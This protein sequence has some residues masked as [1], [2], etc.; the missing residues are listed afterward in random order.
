M[1]V[2]RSKY[3]PGDTV[4]AFVTYKP[5]RAAETIMPVELDLPKDLPQG[6]YQLVISDAV[7]LRAGIDLGA[8]PRHE[9]EIRGRVERL[10]VRAFASA[11]DLPVLQRGTAKRA[12]RVA[13]E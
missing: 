5:F 4:K 7:A 1:N 13:A 2:P 8:A 10:V 3:H 11:R 12:A 9:I 6:T